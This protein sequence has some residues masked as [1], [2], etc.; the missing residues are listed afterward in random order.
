MMVVI[1]VTTV[2]TL[3]YYRAWSI[4]HKSIEHNQ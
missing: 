2:C 4:E 1:I 3:V